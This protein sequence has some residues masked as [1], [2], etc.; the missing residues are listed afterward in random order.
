V[1]RDQ[2]P[3]ITGKW[4]CTRDTLTLNALL[5]KS[6]KWLLLLSQVEFRSAL[7]LEQQLDCELF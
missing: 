4:Q 5:V 6:K 1:V 7:I 2:R 3:G